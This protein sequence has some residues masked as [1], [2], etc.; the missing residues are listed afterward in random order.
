M[1]LGRGSFG[2]KCVLGALSVRRQNRQRQLRGFSFRLRPGLFFAPR[3]DQLLRGA[4]QPL[5]LDCF[6]QE[7]IEA[8]QVFGVRSGRSI[9]PE[10]PLAVRRSG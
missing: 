7:L 5:C 9:R 1:S 4:N 2:E 6:L 10:W 3:D 8:C